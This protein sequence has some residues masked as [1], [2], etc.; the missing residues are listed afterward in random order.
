MPGDEITGPCD[1]GDDPVASIRMEP[2]EVTLA[3]GG[4]APLTA[5]L[6]APDGGTFIFCAPSIFWSSENPLVA[7]ALK[8]GVVAVAPGTTYVTARAGGKAGSVKVTVTPPAPV[9]AR[10]SSSTA[11]R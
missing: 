7:R 6:V 2:A 4:T 8:G 1:G 10:A 5:T 9:D 11:S 3:V